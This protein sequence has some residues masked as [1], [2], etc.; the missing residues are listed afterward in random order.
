MQVFAQ[1]VAVVG[2]GALFARDVVEGAASG[3]EGFMLTADGDDVF[4]L[5]ASKRSRP[6]GFA[7]A[8]MT[9]AAGALVSCHSQ[10]RRAISACTSSVVIRPCGA[11]VARR[12][13]LAVRSRK[14]PRHGASGERAKLR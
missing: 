9:L 1:A 6:S 7:L 4:Q 3:S 11:R 13:M 14:L 10:R 5:Q 2:G 8:G 12:M